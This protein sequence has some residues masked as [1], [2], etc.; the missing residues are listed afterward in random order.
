M[1]D[2]HLPSDGQPA[3]A[4]QPG[5]DW[6]DLIRRPTLEAFASAFAPHASMD[7]S[8]LADTVHGAVPIRELFD[9]TRR[10]YDA[11]AFISEVTTSTRT[12]LEWEGVFQG[13]PVSGVTV[14][15]KDVS[16]LI[17]HVRLYHRPTR[18]VLAFSEELHRLLSA[19]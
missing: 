10:M 18:Q 5:Q 6:F 17:E 4:A 2:L 14:L 9:A 13:A 15:S 12:Y 19:A 16:G 11:I 1:T 7:G 8:V 3:L